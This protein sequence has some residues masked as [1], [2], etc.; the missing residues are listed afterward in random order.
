MLYRQV[1][2]ANAKRVLY[3][4]RAF[5][6]NECAAMGLLDMLAADTALGEAQALAQEI[7]GNAP[8]SL[9]GSKLILEGLSAG[10]IESRQAEISKMVAAAMDSADYREGARAFR[11]S[12]S[13]PSPAD[14]IAH[15]LARRRRRRHLYRSCAV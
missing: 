4:G 13:L 8:L 9:A 2:L 1:G 3:T 11:K 12:A 15:A 5:N 6:A 10:A 7:V 14:R